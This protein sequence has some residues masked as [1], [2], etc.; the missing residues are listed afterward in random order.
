MVRLLASLPFLAAS[1]LLAAPEVP[2]DRRIELTSKLSS[3]GL[4]GRLAEALRSDWGLRALNE[5]IDLLQTAPLL[6]VRSTGHAQWEEYY[7]ATDESGRLQLRPERRAEIDR[8]RARKAAAMARFDFFCKR[9]DDIG[10]RIVAETEPEKEVKAGWK[11]REWRLWMFNAYVCGG[12]PDSDLDLEQVFDTRL[13][14]WLMPSNGKLRVTAPGEPQVAHLV[15]EVYGLLEEVKKYEQPYLKLAAKSDPATAKAASADEVVLLACAKLALDVKAENGD[16]LTKLV[17]L[18]FKDAV[19]DAQ[20][21][22]RAAAQLKPRIDAVAAALADDTRSNDLKTF[23]K[24]DRARILLT[25]KLTPTE[26]RLNQQLDWFFPNILPNGWCD[27]KGD[28]LAFKNNLFRDQQGQNTAA[29]FRAHT[30]DSCTFQLRNLQQLYVS[31]AERCADPEIAE[32]CRDL[33]A[34]A[35]LRQDESRIREMQVAAV[36][37]L[38]LG[39]FTKLYFVEKDGKLVVRPERQKSIESLLARAEELKPKN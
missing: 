35:I 23:L 6:R 18:D 20:A 11:D 34:L 36:Q 26:A 22:I 4:A 31:T 25:V 13:L 15:S 21:M 39:T 7:F 17:A 38:G 32:F 2:E 30:Y 8:L 9:L 33:E 24:D 16:A 14:L 27:T 3:E 1:L 29:Q 5:R 19:R 37:D 10:D 28:K 12:V